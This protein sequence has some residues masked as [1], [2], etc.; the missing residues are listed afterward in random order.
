MKVQSKIQKWG[1]SL[2]IRIGGPM[3]DVP[4]FKEGMPVVVTISPEGLEIKKI[5]STSKIFPFS[6]SELLKEISPESAHADII[7]KPL[8]G[9]F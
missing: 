1:N 9:E 8:D 6:E 7:A 2:A 4:H 3:R 5:E